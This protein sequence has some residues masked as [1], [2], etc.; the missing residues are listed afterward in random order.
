MNWS[1]GERGGAYRGLG[2]R[3]CHFGPFENLHFFM[4]FHNR[5]FSIMYGNIMHFPSDRFEQIFHGR[6]YQTGP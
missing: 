6:H 2:I 1:E 4:N 5:A 3:I